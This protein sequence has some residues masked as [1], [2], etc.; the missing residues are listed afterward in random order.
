MTDTLTPEYRAQLKA[1]AEAETAIKQPV[2]YGV[3]LV[4]IKSGKVE[5][6]NFDGEAG[7]DT[8]DAAFDEARA[9]YNIEGMEILGGKSELFG[10]G[11]FDYDRRMFEQIYARFELV[12]MFDREATQTGCF[13]DNYDYD[14]GGYRVGV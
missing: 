4:K 7:H 6:F 13:A 1:R 2:K 11:K 8:L 9:L 14:V 3:M 10:I 12:D 5:Y